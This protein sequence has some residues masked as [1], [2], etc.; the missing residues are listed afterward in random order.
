MSYVD[1]AKEYA[2]AVHVCDACANNMVQA[3]LPPD[4][5]VI[6][7]EGKDKPIKGEVTYKYSCKIGL[8]NSPKVVKCNQFL[9]LRRDR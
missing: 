5:I 3:R 2:E 4:E 6:D 8:D 9:R 1:I 7:I